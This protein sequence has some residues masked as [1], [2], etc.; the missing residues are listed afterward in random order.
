MHIVTGKPFPPQEAISHDD[1]MV[2]G[3][4]RWL[5]QQREARGWARREMARRLIQ[6]AEAASD[7]TMPGIEHLE[8]YI[9]RWESGRHQLTERYRLFYCT[10]F[11]LRPG[12]FGTA[13]L[14]KPRTLGPPAVSPDRSGPPGAAPL[15]GVVPLLDLASRSQPAAGCDEMD[16]PETDY[17]AVGR[18]VVLA[19]HDASGRVEEAERHRIGEVTRE[20]LHCDVARLARASDT[21]DPAVVFADMDRI[22]ERVCRLLGRRLWPPEQADLYVALGCLNGLM[23]NLAVRLGYPD[24]GEELIR[25]GWAYADPVGHRPLQAQLRQQLSALMFW[26]GRYV[27]ARDLAADGLRYVS[28]GWPGA[29]LYL[30]VARAAAR[31]GDADT[32]RRAIGDAHEARDRDY[33]DEL[34][35]MGGQFALSEA[36]HHSLAG[37]ALTELA[38]TAGEAAEELEHAIGLYEKGPGDREDHWAGGQPLTGIDLALARLRSGALDAAAAALEPAL[39]LPVPLRIAQVTTRLV[40]VRGELAAP[41]YKGSAQA[42]DLA[43]QVEEFTRQTMLARSGAQHDGAA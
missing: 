8:T 37:A 20:Q 12:Q 25:S 3:T 27:E 5:R 41:I 30:H 6:A 43:G 31:L 24:A 15:P 13:P 16:E 11:G 14:P 18:R 1:A 40:V 23:G 38:G 10:A 26:R 36:T 21:G 19:A 9:R 17:P 28:A 33:S 29:G 4:G 22:R 32:A 35:G 34:V 42:R 39:S 2:T 7:A